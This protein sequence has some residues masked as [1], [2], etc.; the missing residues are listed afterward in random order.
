MA[1]LHK[2]IFTKI[3]GGGKRGLNSKERLLDSEKMFEVDWASGPENHNV[4]HLDG[5]LN[6]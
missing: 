5:A 2:H 4:L 1:K 6:P 3:G